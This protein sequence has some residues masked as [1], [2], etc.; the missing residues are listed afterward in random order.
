MIKVILLY[1]DKLK[2]KKNH[3]LYRKCRG[4]M[5]KET[6]V[7]IT[8]PLRDNPKWTKLIHNCNRILTVLVFVAYPLLLLWLL[9]ERNLI[10]ARAIIVPLD[11]FVIL[12]V[13]RYIVNARRPYEVFEMEPVIPKNTKGKSFP[14]RHVFSV[15]IIAMTYLAICPITWIGIV[16]LVIGGLLA[17]VRVV[18][19]VHFPRDVIAGAIFGVAS[20]IVGFWVI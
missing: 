7:N 6:Y 17:V 2:S 10:L 18:S 19:G 9:L 3:L 12:T 8:A 14:S 4:I 15:F 16:L 13:F 20:G 1:K 5:K 11:S